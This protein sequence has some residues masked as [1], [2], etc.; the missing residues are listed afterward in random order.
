MPGTN[1][2]A[3]ENLLLL[4]GITIIIVWSSWYKYS[5]CV[6]RLMWECMWIM[7]VS[8]G[9]FFVINRGASNKWITGSTHYQ[10]EDRWLE[11]WTPCLAHDPC[12]LGAPAV[13]AAMTIVCP[14]PSS[15]EPISP[16]LPSRRWGFK[17]DKVGELTW[18]FIFLIDLSNP[19]AINLVTKH[20]LMSKA[21]RLYS[22]FNWYIIIV[23]IYGVNVIF[24]FIHTV[25]NH[26][27]R[28]ILFLTVASVSEGPLLWAMSFLFTSILKK[29]SF[30]Y[31]FSHII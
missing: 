17:C 22:S 25:C 12:C 23:N 1:D 5:P 28:K 11:C 10:T 26:Q 16:P 31:I 3:P 8:W 6:V 18:S 24:Q 9:W 13:V 15:P 21:I 4:K 19:I 14:F 2:P 29:G 7:V 30:P 20:G 27:I